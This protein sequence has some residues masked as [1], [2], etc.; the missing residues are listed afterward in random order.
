MTYL[1]IYIDKIFA[2]KFTNVHTNCVPST[3][4][5]GSKGFVSISETERKGGQTSHLSFLE[6]IWSFVNFLLDSCI[7]DLDLKER[8][9]KAKKHQRT[10]L[11]SEKGRHSLSQRTWVCT[12][13]QDPHMF[14]NNSHASL[15]I[16]TRKMVTDAHRRS[17]EGSLDLLMVCP[18]LLTLS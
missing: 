3:V 7:L 4:F 18:W 1:T 14:W 2:L 5:H 9:L 16:T 15:A 17:R 13:Q 10:F 6:L 11:C 12:A 8:T